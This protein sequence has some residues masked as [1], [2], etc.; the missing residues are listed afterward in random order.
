MFWPTDFTD[1]L[2]ENLC[3][4]C[5][6]WASN[7]ADGQESMIASTTQIKVKGPLALVRL[8]VY[9]W[10]VRRQ[11]AKSAGLIKFD[12]HPG[13]RTLTIWESTEALKAFRNS[14]A[15]LEAMRNTYKIGSAR[16]VTW[17]V[18]EIPKWPE[19][20]AKLDS[21]DTRHDLNRVSKPVA[22]HRE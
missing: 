22:A 10:R 14:G 12:F 5:Y 15:H 21:A 17:E 16:T 3:D 7:S 1:R 19:V 20:I 8:L 18:T 9:I 2:Q 4:L 13:W 11:L 6:L